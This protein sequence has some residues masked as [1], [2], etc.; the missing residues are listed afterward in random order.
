MDKITSC[1]IDPKRFEILLEKVLCCFKF[2]LTMSLL[3]PI[4]VT[5]KLDM[6]EDSFDRIL[7]RDIHCFDVKC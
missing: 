5:V 6:F 7:F 2:H 1:D 4:E 3:A